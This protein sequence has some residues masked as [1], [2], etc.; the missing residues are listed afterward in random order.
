MTRRTDNVALKKAKERLGKRGETPRTVDAARIAGEAY[1]RQKAVLAPWEKGAILKQRDIMS[2]YE[3][4][5]VKLSA[6]TAA[7]DRELA[8]QL[9]AFVASM[10][11]PLS[12]RLAHAQ[13]FITQ[14]DRDDAERKGREPQTGSSA[15]LRDA[16]KASRERKPSRDR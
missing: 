3:A 5:S 7:D 14:R 1:A 16:A 11:G 2:A 12:H 13:A 9:T 6:S 4:V 8:R 15:R 10:P